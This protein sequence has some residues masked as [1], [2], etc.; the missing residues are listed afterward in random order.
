MTSQERDELLIR[1]DERTERLE[2]WTKTHIALH[3]RL[4]AAFIA[5]SVSTVLALGTTL[6]SVIVLLA[7]RSSGG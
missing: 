1:L 3:T 4:S 7:A 2:E 5:A 6:A